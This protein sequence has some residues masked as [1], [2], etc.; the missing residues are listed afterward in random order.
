MSKNEKPLILATNDDGI[1]SNFLIRLVEALS[2]ECEVITCAPDGERSWIGHAI[3][4]HQTL[5]PEKVKKY[6]GKEAYSVN[7]TPADCVNLAVGNLLDREPDVVVS[8]INLGYNVTMPMILSS[9]TVGGA[10]E[11]SLLGLRAM[12]VSLALPN[13]EFDQIR[14][15][16]GKVKGDMAKSLDAAAESAAKYAQILATLP[17]PEGLTVH[18]LNYPPAYDG[19]EDPILTFA[20]SLKLNSLFNLTDD[21]KSYQL[22]YR[23]EWLDSARVE[24]GSDLW[25]LQENM[26]TVSRLD[27]SEASG[28]RYLEP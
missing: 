4:R 8:G 6:P 20:N 21:G 18:N 22:T 25:A 1:N 19:K 27:F 17:V 2:K 26:A 14:D 5:K 15:S 7:G 11:A 10:M 9:G 23:T 16:G 28:K 24:V 12:A 3:T 13:E